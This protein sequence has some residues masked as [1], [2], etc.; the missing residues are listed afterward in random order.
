LSKNYRTFYP[1]IVTKLSKIW[2]CDPGSK[3]RDPRSGIRDPDKTYSGSR[4]LDP[5]PEGKKAQDP[6]YRIRIRKT[7]QKNLADV[8]G[9]ES[10]QELTR[11]FWLMSVVWRVSKSLPEESG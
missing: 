2:V 9:V 3:I 11:R 6:G 8:C 10:I 1:K 7:Y 5:G 4:I